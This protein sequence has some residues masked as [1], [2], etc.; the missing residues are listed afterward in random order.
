VP[1]IDDLGGNVPWEV[2]QNC[3]WWTDGAAEEDCVPLD[4]SGATITAVITAS[5]TSSTV[6]KAFTVTIIDGPGGLWEIKI[7]ETDADLAPG[8]YWWAME[9]DLGDGDEPVCS[10]PF[11]VKPWV[12]VP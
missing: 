3:V 6:L 8:T 10:G 2:R 5:A 11:V 9:W 7:D 4:I 1:T 12:I